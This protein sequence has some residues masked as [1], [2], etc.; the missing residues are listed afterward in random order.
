VK[1]PRDEKFRMIKKTNEAIKK[2]LLSLTPLTTLHDLILTM[3]YVEL[4]E[5]HYIFVGDYFTIL[6]MAQ[7]IV[8]HSLNK[9]KSKYMSEEERKRYEMA[10]QKRLEVLE[11]NR[12]K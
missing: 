8:E 12:K 2:K 5:E 4:D 7:G 10:E 1:N 6:L 9:I 11:E 3:G